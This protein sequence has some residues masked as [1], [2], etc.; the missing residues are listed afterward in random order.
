MKTRIPLP[1]CDGVFIE[2]DGAKISKGRREKLIE[3]FNS[4][5]FRETVREIMREND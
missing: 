4:I 1:E 2:F 3:A 5:E